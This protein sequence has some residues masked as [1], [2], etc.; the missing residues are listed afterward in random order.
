MRMTKA[1]IYFIT[2][3]QIEQIGVDIHYMILNRGWRETEVDNLIKEKYKLQ[4]ATGLK[5]R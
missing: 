3:K 2:K 5:V 1:N 4:K